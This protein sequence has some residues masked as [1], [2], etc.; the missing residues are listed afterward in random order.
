MKHLTTIFMALC[1]CALTLTAQQIEYVDDEEC[2]C[3]LVYVDG[4]QTTTDG[5]L[6]GFRLGSTASV[7][8]TARS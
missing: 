6:Y 3:E 1:I 2:G 4:I 5:E 8:P 7:W